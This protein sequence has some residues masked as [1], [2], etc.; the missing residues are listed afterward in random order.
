M[1]KLDFMIGAVFWGIIALFAGPSILNWGYK[2]MK[3]EL[4][5]ELHKGV[6]VDM[7]KFHSQL[8][9]QKSPF[10]RKEQ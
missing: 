3:T 5:T 9:G 2:A 1:E 4:I 7:E 6:A 10:A 8:T